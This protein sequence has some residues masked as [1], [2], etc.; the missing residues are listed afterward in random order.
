LRGASATKQSSR[1]NK[2]DCFASL[3]MTQA[4]IQFQL[5]RIAADWVVAARPGCELPGFSHRQA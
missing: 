4:S 5:I 3:A 2:L 1:H